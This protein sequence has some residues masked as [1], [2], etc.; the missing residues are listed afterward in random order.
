MKS[1]PPSPLPEPIPGLIH[2]ALFVR[3]PQSPLTEEQ[4]RTHVA[5]IPDMSWIALNQLLAGRLLN[6]VS[7]SR[8]GQSGDSLFKAA[9]RIAENSEFTGDLWRLS[10]RAPQQKAS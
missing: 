5:N 6:A 9:G 8:D 4:L 3:L 1:K 10:G 2:T 7:D